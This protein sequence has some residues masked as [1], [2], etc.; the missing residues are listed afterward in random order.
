L[1]VEKMPT[2]S[3]RLLTALSLTFSL[4]ALCLQFLLISSLT[5]IAIILSVSAGT[6]GGIVLAF[7]ISLW[8]KRYQRDGIIVLQTRMG[9]GLIVYAG[10]L[11]LLA[12]DVLVPTEWSSLLCKGDSA[13][14][15][16]NCRV[17]AGLSEVVMQVALWAF[18]F[19][20]G[21]LYEAK[22]GHRLIYRIPFFE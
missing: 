2:P 22:I 17:M 8:I 1:S 11:A 21:F 20:W 9:G 7:L 12:C 14:E 15:V 16:Q 3:H 10:L 6:V 18:L 19:C 4:A 5:N 13:Q